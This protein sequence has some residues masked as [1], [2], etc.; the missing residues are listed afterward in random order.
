MLAKPV[1]VSGIVAENVSQLRRF[2]RLLVRYTAGEY[3]PLERAIISS[4]RVAVTPLACKPVA[5]SGVVVSVVVQIGSE[6]ERLVQLV[7]RDRRV[8]D[9]VAEGVLHRH[10]DVTL[11][12]LQ[13]GMTSAKGGPDA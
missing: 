6:G 5:V 1:A 10:N 11:A 12:D 2:P 7:E 4:P 8:G 9:G 3:S 13:D